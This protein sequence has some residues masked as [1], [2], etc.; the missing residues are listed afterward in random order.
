MAAEARS[1][2]APAALPQVAAVAR[3][4]VMTISV[5]LSA[6]YEEPPAQVSSSL[7]TRCA[8]RRGGPRGRGSRRRDDDTSRQGTS[9]LN[10]QKARTT[11]PTLTDGTW[12]LVSSG[13]TTTA[14][15]TVARM[16]ARATAERS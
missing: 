9:R 15:S 16:G 13:Q 5:K 12:A 6:D 10:S 1:T 14:T 7:G 4:T 11:L 3:T 8:P 2:S